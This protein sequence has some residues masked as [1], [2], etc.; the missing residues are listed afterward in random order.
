MSSMAIYARIF[1]LEPDDEYVKKRQRAAVAIRGALATLSP[2]SLALEVASSVADAL[3]T[4]TL[5]KNVADI[6]GSA[7]ASESNSFVQEGQHLQM[8]VCA[9]VA[10]LDLI[11][12]ADESDGWTPADALAAGLWSALSFQPSHAEAQ[13][14][15][16]RDSLLRASRD[17][18]IAIAAASRRR[19]DVPEIGKLSI[20]ETSPIG[21]RSNTAFREAA[22]PLVAA[23]RNNAELDREEIDLLWW[24]LADHSDTI[25]RPMTEMADA[26]RAVVA[27]VDGAAK[28]RKLPSH[29]HRNLILRNVRQDGGLALSEV[30]EQM[31]DDR[32]KLGAKFVG[33]IINNAPTVF[34]LLTALVSGQVRTP[35]GDVKY[36]PRDWGARALLEASI[37]A[38]DGRRAYP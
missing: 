2:P 15:S 33:S 23:L 16:L 36:S 3:Q 37:L 9:M 10:A 26:S 28:L 35:G 25:D 34:P 30:L 18:V 4:G 5:P 6:V 13:V 27:G 21:T 22:R 8:L 7:L 24:V 31:G 1:K 11:Q 19:A 12:Q 14:E 17:R 29:G 32:E 20:P 38:T